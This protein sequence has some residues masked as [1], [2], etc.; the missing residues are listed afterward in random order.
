MKLTSFA[1]V[2]AATAALSTSACSHFKVLTMDVA[3]IIAQSDGE[4]GGYKVTVTVVDSLNA[5]GSGTMA[6]RRRPLVAAGRHRDD[7]QPAF[8]ACR[9]TSGWHC[10]SAGDHSGHH[11]CSGRCADQ[12]W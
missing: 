2:S 1:V 5:E 3:E 7:G 9:A 6:R 12:G 8:G 4:C 10:G 11:Q